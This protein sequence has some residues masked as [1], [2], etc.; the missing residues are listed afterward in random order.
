MSE[1]PW[2]AVQADESADVG[3]GQQCL[4]LG[5]MFSRRMCKRT[6]YL[7]FCCQPAPQPLDDYVS[8]NGVGH[9]VTVHAVSA[10][11]RMQRL[12]RLEGFLVSLLGQTLLL[13]MSI[14]CV[15]HREPNAG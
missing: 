2:N 12:P 9:C 13:D 15:I 14:S 10:Y 5:Y 11:T 1:S 8:G 4:F 3:N 6:G 7:H